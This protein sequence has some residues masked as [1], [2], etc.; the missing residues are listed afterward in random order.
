MRHHLVKKSVGTH[1]K[2]LP[3]GIKVRAAGVKLAVMQ[4][5]FLPYL[6]Y[7]QLMA[8]VDKFVIYDDVAFIK[9]G[10]INRNRIL[11]R[12]REHLLSLP[13]RRASQN[14]LI[15][16]ISLDSDLRWRKKLLDTIRHAYRRAP[17][18][19]DVFPLVRGILECAEENL[20]QYLHH[21]LCTVKD[22]LAIQCRLIPTSAIY[23]N[24]GLKGEARILDICGREKATEYFNPS[25][26][27]E[28]YDRETF[29]ACGVALHFLEAGTP[30]YPQ[31]GDVYRPRLSIIDVL[32]FNP[33]EKVKLWLVEAKIS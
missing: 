11:V 7:F 15:N 28:L 4:P 12:D 33:L 21:S 25:G 14:R 6:G 29:R 26:G 9:R 17:Q 8:A 13:L 27:T 19:T 10:W 24:R 30:E 23:D 20:A 1:A 5:Y 22:Y 31:F 32:M 18:F 2:A 16:E 3:E